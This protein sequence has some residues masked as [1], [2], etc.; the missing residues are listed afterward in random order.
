MAKKISS[1]QRVLDA[2][3][4]AGLDIRI[5]EMPDSTRTAEEAASACGCAVDQIVKSLIFAP[6][7]AA[8]N[9]GGLKLFLISGAH[10]L[11]MNVARSVTG[12]DFVRADP[13]VVREVTG[14]AIGGVAPIGHLTALP[15]WM[16]AHLLT[17]ATVW[18]AAGAPNAVFE[19]APSALQRATG[20]E[21]LQLT[22]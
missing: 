22:R 12:H 2:A 19:V 16:D 15:T 11:D 5:L 6:K 3:E 21:L 9:S 10:Q 8:Q 18:A 7:E 13:R 4:A 1:R 14:F 17:F 20:A